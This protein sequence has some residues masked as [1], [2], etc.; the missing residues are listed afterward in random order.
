[1]HPNA[2]LILYHCSANTGYAISRLEKIF[3]KMAKKLV[4][5][6]KRIHLAYLN[7]ERGRPNYLPEN[8]ANLISIDTRLP[9]H[10]INL[11]FRKYL[12]S[13]SIDLCFA[14]DQPVFR[15]AYL[16]LRF[17]GIRR[18]VSYWGAPMS[19][20]NYGLKLALKRL[21]VRLTPFQ[22]DL[23]IFESN[24][25]AQTAITGRG[26]P[27]NKV[28]IIHLGVDHE[29][30]QPSI[31]ENFYAHKSFDIPDERKII[32]YSGHMESR[33]GVAVLIKSM[34]RL[35]DI[36]KRSDFHLLIMGNKNNEELVYKELYLNSK[37]S[38]YITFGGYRTDVH[39]IIPCCYLGVIPSTG[40]DSFTMSALEIAACGLP[41]IVSEL[42]GLPETIDVGLSGLTFPVGDAKALCEQIIYLDKNPSI[43]E[44]MCKAARNRIVTKFT[45]NQQLEYLIQTIHDL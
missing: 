45:A 10:L 8:F 13:N 43:Y 15:Y 25:M 5:N 18:F 27:E 44:Q 24:A 31:A 14:F 23:Y 6:E 41:L 12:S 36:N 40:W 2:M 38:E 7:Y 32:Y 30:F 11:E 9:K 35:I 20:C 3:Y 19:S 33:K 1:M 29:L 34:M 17:G 22:P 16:P 28:K 39:K 21:Q 37:A 42:Q 4:S 26:I